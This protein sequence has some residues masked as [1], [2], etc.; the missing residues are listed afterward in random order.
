MKLFKAPTTNLSSYQPKERCEVT[1]SVSYIYN[2]GIVINDEWYDGY[3]V[4]PPIIS[5]GYGIVDIGVGLQLNAEPPYATG[6]L[7][8][9]SL[10]PKGTSYMDYTGEWKRQ[11]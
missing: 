7:K 3:E 10:I 5:I 11:K 9:I 4:P 8:P 1:Y 2:G 6:V